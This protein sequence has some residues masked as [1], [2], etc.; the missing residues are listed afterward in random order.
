MKFFLLFFQDYFVTLPENLQ[1][2][3]KIIRVQASDADFRGSG[4]LRYSVSRRNKNIARNLIEVDS[5]TGD[6]TLRQT[7]DRELHDK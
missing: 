1:S 4:T 7:L 3:R 2:G 5:V 6:V